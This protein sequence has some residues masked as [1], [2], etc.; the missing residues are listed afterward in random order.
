MDVRE[1]T[2]GD[3]EE[4]ARL[5]TDW[6]HEVLDATEPACTTDE[7]AG[8]FAPRPRRER[9]AFLALDDGSAVG[10]ARMQLRTDRPQPGFVPEL[11]VARA[12]R[13]NGT[14]RALVSAL[15]GAGR[16]AGA[17]MLILR[18]DDSSD[19]G[20]AFADALGA[21]RGFRGL[22]SRCQI[23]DVD[24]DLLRSWVDR[25]EERASGWS[26][27]RWS[28]RCPD[29]AFDAFV[30]VQAAMDGAAIPVV[31][32]VQSSGAEIREAEATNAALGI[33]H[34]VLAAR[35]DA[36]GSLGGF[37]EIEFEPHT[38]WLGRQGDTAVMPEHRGLGLGRW[39]K[40]TM[41]QRVMA[42]RPDVTV[43]ETNTAMDNP[44]MRAINEAMGF[45]VAV[46]WQDR[47]LALA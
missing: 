10:M 4:L 34:W 20:A 22:Q 24:P 28:G 33:D 9:R 29:E 7:A 40:A 11:F 14:G 27:V 25:A 3:A 31:A 47:E 26:L 42:E 21:R 35:H 17:P 38:P 15:A 8:W 46:V 23:S 2:S 30:A 16:A 44:P 32:A 37:T 43:L 1:A 39:L 13:R 18:Q 19:V 45:R 12:A 6:R 36:T 5:V 41:A